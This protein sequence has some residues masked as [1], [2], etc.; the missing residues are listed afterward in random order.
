MFITVSRKKKPQPAEKKAMPAKSTTTSEANHNYHAM[1][2]TSQSNVSFLG[3]KVKKESTKYICPF[4]GPQKRKCEHEFTT[5]TALQKHFQRAHNK[6][7]NE[8]QKPEDTVPNNCRRIQNNNKRF[9]L[10]TVKMKLCS[11]LVGGKSVIDENRQRLVAQV[12]KVQQ[13]PSTSSSTKIEQ[14]ENEMAREVFEI[15]EKQAVEL[16][17][18]AILFSH[19][20]Y[21][22]IY[23]FITTNDETVTDMA[24]KLNIDW[25]LILLTFKKF[26][27]ATK[28]SSIPNSKNTASDNNVTL[29]T[30][31]GKDFFD[32]C[33]QYNVVTSFEQWSQNAW[34]YIADTFH[35]NFKNNIMVHLYRRLR[36]WFYFRL[37]NGRTKKYLR[38]K[39]NNKKLS[40][41]VYHTMKFLFEDE[42]CS[43]PE[44]VQHELIAELQSICKF[45]EFNKSGQ[46][47]FSRL[48]HNED[49][50]D[51]KP[52]KSKKAKL[53]AP[54]KSKKP[55]KTVQSNGPR[56]LWIQMVPGFVRLQGW[57]HATNLN[58]D[59][60]LREAG[61][62]K[63]KNKRK[64]K[65]KRKRNRLQNISDPKNDTDDVENQITKPFIKPHRKRRQKRKQKYRKTDD[66]AIHY[67]KLRNFN[68]VPQ[69]SFA[70]KHFAIDTKS[71]FDVVKNLKSFHS[72]DGKILFTQNEF[73]ELIN[74]SENA[75][76]KTMNPFWYYIFNL[77]K[78]ETVTRKF[79]GRITTNSSD[80]SVQLCRIKETKRMSREEVIDLASRKRKANDSDP[81]PD[82]ES[83]SEDNNETLKE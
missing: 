69:H 83:E 2:R 41:E 31:D 58:R 7:K 35:T 43:K 63:P 15:M 67:E 53:T 72:S 79:G 4:V 54:K 5:Y 29:Y 59:K 57:I 66:D 60:E 32:M 8:L 73:V 11:L 38:D 30:I 23:R 68:V 19:L 12:N 62:L 36:N 37:R 13:P 78:L 65:R 1:I 25:N 48:Y 34:N 77:K 39:E 75:N 33:I 14:K 10:T 45:P 70:M 9:H 22:K 21:Y 52:S 56:L 55:K 76:V 40:D 26:L 16:S 6:Q 20:V 80:V 46:S 50:S 82:V 42:K 47:Y 17:K 51:T 64:R 28:N 24:F 71:L 27:R 44:M 61:I 18:L 74:D 81:E 49:E 3:N